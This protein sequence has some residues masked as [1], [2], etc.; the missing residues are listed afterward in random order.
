MKKR[1]TLKIGKKERGFTLIELLIVIAILGV[2][3]AVVVPNVMGLLGKGGGQAYETD[4]S[5][6]MT[7]AATFW[8]DVHVGP[9]IPNVSWSDTD[10]VAG[11]WFPVANGTA[12]GFYESTNDANNDDQG[13][14]RILTADGNAAAIGDITNAAIW[15]GLLVNNE[16]ANTTAGVTARDVA[17]PQSGE[18]ELYLNDYPKSCSNGDAGNGNPSTPGGTYTWIVGANGKVFGA[19]LGSDNTYYYSGFGGSYP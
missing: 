7:A 12:S 15:M 10:G 6:I 3:A 5:T 11:H 19:Y 18:D 2:L 8:G 17:A 4:K 14:P 1:L 13:N 9:D 16:A